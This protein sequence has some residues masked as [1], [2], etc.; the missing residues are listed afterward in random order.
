MSDWSHFDEMSGK[1]KQDLLSLDMNYHF[2]ILGP[3]RDMR[4]M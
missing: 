3:F 2:K 4:V 1:E